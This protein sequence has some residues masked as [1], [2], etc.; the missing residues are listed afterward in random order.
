MAFCWFAAQSISGVIDGVPIAQLGGPIVATAVSVLMRSLTQA[1]LDALAVQGAARVKSQLRARVIAAIDAGGSRLLGTTSSARIATLLGQGL[2]A[3]DGYIGRYLPQ[4]ILTAVA[5][6][7]IV[8][9]LLLAD[10]ATGITVILTLPIIPVFMVL[11]G[12][13]TRAVQRSQW[14]QLGA[15]A[16]GFVE[17]VHGLS[18]LIVFGRQHGQ[19][20][21]IAAVTDE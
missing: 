15:L 1:L 2:D 5:T 7:I 11:I 20:E 12:L 16:Q 9:V 10:L 4:L 13:S 19:T 21:R 17:V 14:Q 6:P 8:A 18:T 3:L